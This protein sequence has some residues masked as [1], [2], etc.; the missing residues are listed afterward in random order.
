MKHANEN[1]RRHL[2]GNV[3]QM[4]AK[5]SM[6]RRRSERRFDGRTAMVFV[7]L[8][9]VNPFFSIHTVFSAVVVGVGV[10]IR[11]SSTGY[12]FPYHLS[13]DDH[14]HHI[15]YAVTTEAADSSVRGGVKRQVTRGVVVWFGWSGILGMT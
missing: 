11:W 8:I 3:F 5:V 13:H 2:T 14:R 7:F 15:I 12:S 9:V 6:D 1:N 4:T 10:G